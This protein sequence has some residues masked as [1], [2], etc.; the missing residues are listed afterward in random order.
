MVV[1]NSIPRVNQKHVQKAI[2]MLDQTVRFKS[3][4]EPEIAHFLRI[5]GFGGFA[6]R[7]TSELSFTALGVIGPVGATPRCG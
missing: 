1:Q 3:R 4:L 2:L 5:P 7:T 6:T